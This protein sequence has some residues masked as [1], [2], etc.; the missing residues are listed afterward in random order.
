MC[1]I[2]LA[3][4]CTSIFLF[5]RGGLVSCRIGC[6][7]WMISPPFLLTDWS[8]CRRPLFHY[9]F[10]HGHLE[11]LPF[12]GPLMLSLLFAMWNFWFHQSM[13]SRRPDGFPFSDRRFI[14]PLAF[15]DPLVGPLFFRLFEL[16]PF[17]YSRGADQY[18][19]VHVEY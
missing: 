6:L 19:P 9:F 16:I 18:N 8:F 3:R 10:G 5:H 4:C 13:E 7:L 11:C 2:C 1:S 17:P 14:L 15:C 12:R